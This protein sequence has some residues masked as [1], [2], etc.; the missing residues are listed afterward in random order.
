[1]SKVAV[2]TGGTGGL[3][4][5]V[6]R[7][8]LSAGYNVTVTYRSDD[9]LKDLL[10]YCDDFK[11]ELDAHRIDVTDEA[12]LDDLA[13]KVAKKQGRL[14]VLLC[15]VGGFAMGTFGENIGQVLDTMM[16]IN[17][18][19]YLLACNALVPLMKQTTKKE[20]G[21]YGHI[22]GVASRPALMPDFGKGIG[23]YAASKAA[24]VNLTEV[25]AAELANDAITVNAIAPS[26]I[27]TAA[28][29]KAMPKADP[30]TWVKPEAIARTLL[31]LASDQSNSTTG[32]IIPV[33]G[34]A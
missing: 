31:Y 20:R 9:E 4:K 18:R 3:G 24:V 16:A 13:E 32:A 1:M 28:N 19:S 8:F 6:T 25:M 29:R 10:E 21:S 5:A 34:K 11:K 30:K 15:L 17:A 22:I 7:A 33:Y 14:D 23:A 26:T 27:D 12:S 2:I